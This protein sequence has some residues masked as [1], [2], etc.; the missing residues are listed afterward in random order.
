MGLPRDPRP[1]PGGIAKGVIK[2]CPHARVSQ[3]DVK[4]AAACGNEAGVPS[5]GCL[6]PARPRRAFP[7]P[8][9]PQLRHVRCREFLRSK[10][11]SREAESGGL[12]VK[13]TPLRL[14]KHP[15]LFL[16]C[17]PLC[18]LLRCPGLAELCRKG[19]VPH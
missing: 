12:W 8:P 4:W 16:V 3:G 19:D 1:S 7:S 15:V 13:Q 9:S 17:S 18:Y 5:S 14:V 2:P 11:G 10:A 6:T